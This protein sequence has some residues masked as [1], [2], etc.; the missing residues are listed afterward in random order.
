MGSPSEDR[1]AR[2]GRL[3]EEALGLSATER[4]TWLAAVEAPADLVD[5]LR[6]L[7]SVHE[8]GV[9]FLDSLADG[10]KPPTL[11]G[12]EFREVIGRGGMGVVWAARQTQ[13]DREVAIKLLASSLVDLSLA[14]FRREISALGRLEHDSIA[15]VYEAGMAD[16]RPFIVMERVKGAPIDEHLAAEGQLEPILRT[17]QD[18]C[19]GVAHAHA[20]GIIH[21]DLKP[22]NVLVTAD[23]QV[24]ILD[25]GIARI[26]D[27]GDD[28][29]PTLQTQTGMILGTLPYMSPEQARGEVA[30]I[31]AHSD[32]YSLGVML[33]ELVEG[34]RPLDLDD[35]PLDRAITRIA[36]DQP[37]PLTLR[38]RRFEKDLSVILGKALA[39]EPERRFETVAAFSEDIDRLLAAEPILA[40]PPST[41]YL[42]TRFAQRHRVLVTAVA[43]SMLVLMAA[44]VVSLSFA[45][46]VQKA[47]V[48]LKEAQE[49]LE[50]EKTQA[51]E[52][53]TRADREARTANTFVDFMI[54][55]L[56]EGDPAEM[57][58]PSL[59]G[60]I[61]RV[62]AGVD[63]D[64]GDQPVVRARLHRFLGKMFEALGR[65]EQSVSH[66]EL[67]GKLFGEYAP[68]H[69]DHLPLMLERAHGLL[70]VER[71]QEALDEVDH[72][73]GELA[74][75]GQDRSV[76]EARGL[77]LRSEVLIQ[78]GR[79][80]EALAAIQKSIALAG[81]LGATDEVES[82]LHTLAGALLWLGRLDESRA[83][84]EK[85][86]A[87]RRRKYSGANPYVAEALQALA[88]VICQGD[89]PEESLPVLD[90]ALAI[91]R[92]TLG[93][94]HSAT[95]TTL[96]TRAQILGELGRLEEALADI[97]LAE[98]LS[99]ESEGIDSQQ[100]QRCVI[101]RGTFLNGLG[102]ADEALQC[103]R[104]FAEQLRDRDFPP[105]LIDVWMNLAYV[106]NDLG[107][108]EESLKWLKEGLELIRRKIPDGVVRVS[109][110]S[111][112]ANM[113]MKLEAWQLAA[114]QFAEIEALGK[115][116]FRL[117]D[118]LRRAVNTLQEGRAMMKLGRLDESESLI[119]AAAQV[120]DQ[121]G[122][123]R[124]K[125]YDA[126]RLQADLSRTKGNEARARELE[127]R[128]EA[129][130]GDER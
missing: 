54:R 122:V 72:F 42:L 84:L 119:L 118:P 121:D 77:R 123:P 120:L 49:N 33:Y 64:L 102:R 22:A 43:F 62:A 55:T 68:D 67:A 100:Y 51:V 111:V 36:E 116:G 27:Q 52:S 127:A 81:D 103:M 30:A 107:H 5:E 74:R 93:A 109:Y 50:R 28:D 47:N 66:L 7:L 9:P 82:G 13:P 104:G 31:G 6:D 78:F 70:R 11:E 125:R 88:V 59:R 113:A 38:G 37:P 57:E 114:D 58:E 26:L 46:D 56:L 63:R 12:Y 32:V 18:V 16:G 3:F 99:A 117:E 19:R 21:R 76:D 71:L 98:K 41:A 15:R 40:R 8:G 39:K 79:L 101:I 90:E 129:L 45:F 25:F 35:L 2:L 96:S 53:A 83:Q 34:R 69:A 91:Q 17:F 108:R 106:E 23:G 115:A 29:L 112:S 95:I 128:A 105:D 60:A 130:P 126:I 110:L 94:S 124:S 65:P 97:E 1:H 24:K 73:L 87:I 75:L 86:L 10:S 85:L 89:H 48:E 92:E 14:R 4:E 80:E 20:R 61:E 44:T